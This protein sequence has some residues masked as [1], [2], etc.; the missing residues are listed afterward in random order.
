MIRLAHPIKYARHN[1]NIALEECV[2]HT[3]NKKL[4]KTLG[5][6]TQWDGEL[7]FD[8]ITC[9]PTLQLLNAFINQGFF[10]F[11]RRRSRCPSFFGCLSTNSDSN[12][13]QGTVVGSYN[14]WRLVHFWF[15]WRCCKTYR[16]ELSWWIS[17]VVVHH[18]PVV[19]VRNVLQSSHV[20]PVV[21]LK[22]F[23]YPKRSR[24][25]QNVVVFVP[26]DTELCD[27]RKSFTVSLGRDILYPGQPH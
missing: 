8:D 16:P 3:F 23:M 15:H 19:C 21:A 24:S 27:Q 17:P 13:R 18:L 11:H 25:N 26:S 1:G 20:V 5:A 22:K 12:P 4:D 6:E 14:S 10:F 2:A 9:E 7:G